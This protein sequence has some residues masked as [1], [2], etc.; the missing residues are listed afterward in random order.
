MID[1]RQRDAE[2]AL[3]RDL[4]A[5]RS[6]TDRDLPELEHTAR[7]LRSHAVAEDRRSI[8]EGFWMRLRRGL[9]AR[10]GLAIAGGVVMM[11]VILGVV[12]VSYQRT[13]GHEVT[14][15]LA[16][17]GLDGQTVT[18]IAS[19]LG[20][21]LGARQV[22]VEPANAPGSRGME[23]LAR[24]PARR[25]GDIER[26]ANAFA[27]ALGKRGLEARVSV[28][29][30]RERV[31]TSLYAFAM[32]RVVNLNVQ[33]AGRSPAEIESDIRA[34]LEASGIENSQVQVSREGDQTK[35]TIQ[36]DD[37][38][39][40]ESEREFRLN[41]QTEGG[42]SVNAQIHRFDVERKPGMT[43]ADVKADI[44]RQMREA[45]VQGEVTVENGEVR[46]NVEKHEQRQ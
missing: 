33:L 43:D 29:P 1:D 16:A 46:I 3:E 25:R 4:Q 44:E 6:A 31:S 36:A 19:E 24:V 13:T 12:P 7:I 32:D 41:L 27:S 23:I 22:L 11:A 30:Q 18:K 42:D 40:D 17:P 14:M 26:V 38:S 2:R 21:A 20:R 8:E 39:S 34:Q 28:L 45:G 9:S 37:S 5:Y 35:V 10:P 15:S